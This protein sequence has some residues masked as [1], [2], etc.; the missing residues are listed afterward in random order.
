[1]LSKPAK[2]IIGRN[3]ELKKIHTIL[4]N[5][6][7]DK[8]LWIH[9]RG[10]IGSGKSH[11]IRYLY[12][13]SLPDFML[14]YRFNYDLFEFGV[15]IQL[16]L[17]FQH[18]YRSFTKE[19]EAL[20]NQYPHYLKFAI[21]E[22]FQKNSDFFQDRGLRE[23]HSYSNQFYNELLF[24]IL[25]FFSTKKRKPLV[26]LENVDFK[27]NHHMDLLDSLTSATIP[28]LIITSGLEE[29]TQFYHD[30]FESINLQKLSAIDIQNFIRD[31]L[32]I[33]EN[34]A[35][36]I[37]NHIQFKSQGIPGRIKFL[38]EAHYRDIIP[39]DSEEFIDTKKLRQI[40]ISPLLEI[41]FQ[42]MLKQLSDIEISIFSFLSRLIDPPP[43]KI[44]EKVLQKLKMKKGI[45]KIW[46]EKGY[47]GEEE[48]SSEKFVFLQSNLKAFLTR[49][50]EAPRKTMK[51]IMEI[52]DDKSTLKKLQFPLQLSHIYF[53][54]GDK[55]TGLDFA[56]REARLLRSLNLQQR[57]YERY[58]FIKRNFADY[59]GKGKNYE[60]VF[61]ETGELQK[62][63]GLYENA[64]ESFRELR[65]QIGKDDKQIWFSASLQMAD[66]LLE[67][68][69]FAEAKYLLNDLKIKKAADAHTK[70]YA[71]MLL[72]DLDKNL[73]RDDYALKKYEKA[74][75]L[76]DG[77]KSEV[78]QVGN[79]NQE[80]I[81]QLYSKIRKI[82]VTSE[83]GE[84]LETLISKAVRM[85]RKGSRYHNI[86][87]LDL[88]K[89][90]MD[91][92]ELKR[93]R[94]IAI[95]LLHESKQRFDPSIMTQTVLYLV[96]VYAYFSKWYLARSHLRQLVQ[97]RLF[98]TSQ[99][100]RVRIFMHLAVIEKEIARYGE[101]LKLLKQAE[102]MCMEENYSREQNEIKIHKGHIQ[103]LVHGYLRQR[104]FLAD[105]LNWS[106]EKQDQE[107]FI[108]ASLYMSSYELQQGRLKKA[109]KHLDEARS[110]ISESG[111]ELDKLNYI[112]YLLQYL[113][114]TD[115]FQRAERIAQIWQ[116]MSSGITKF[117]NLALWF[118]AK[119]LL[120]QGDFVGAL[121]N[122][123]L[124]LERSRR[125]HLPH[126]E[127]HI[128]KEMVDLCHQS[129]LDKEIRKFTSQL[130]SAFKMLLNAIE[131]E[132]LTKQFSESREVEELV[133]IGIK[134]NEKVI[135]RPAKQAK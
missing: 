130:Q 114:K 124:I 2:E 52:L 120:K 43:M 113:L 96:E 105:A 78:K 90:L 83:N 116:D 8:P 12:E 5:W 47:L 76:L 9:I 66:I 111:N 59:P 42:N 24:Q 25:E 32:R 80:L 40:R 100:I 46:I 134:L 118:K 93:A 4:E 51:K 29:P 58:N 35:R 117:E 127:F 56:H 87:R 125:Y 89:Y 68:D 98:F 126:L 75:S 3:S 30:K 104:E 121:S 13:Q 15:N 10:E 11:L 41:I 63:L 108:V 128:L 55:K 86:A 122:Y 57:A 53:Q 14:L 54:I 17:L 132:I 97:L 7:K 81:F 48:L 102:K 77:D 131:D 84:E 6:D 71:I 133:K 28:M 18:I 39:D 38:L 36:F 123:K 20:L 31:Y 67:M 60:A 82:F 26:V 110:Q 21:L 94:K 135:V 112:F 129:G 85:M 49:Q 22:L 65:D 70:S 73:G 61:R 64:F 37:A 33:N 34:N 107:L 115:R 119:S 23:A 50:P 101:A 103:L 88:L 44:L 16:N 92:K 91:Q 1:L 95:Q 109:K 72:G 69:A 19:I 45:L 99:R 79:N 62:S 106:I 74:L 27:K